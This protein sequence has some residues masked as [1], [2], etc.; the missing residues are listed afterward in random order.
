MVAILPEGGYLSYGLSDE[1]CGQANGRNPTRRRIPL[2]CIA[3]KRKKRGS[4]VAILPEGGYLSYLRS[5]NM[6]Q[7][8]YFSMQYILNI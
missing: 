4:R 3:R 5:F 7:I 1:E 2:L 6:F 8:S